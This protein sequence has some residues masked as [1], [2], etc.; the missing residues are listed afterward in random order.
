MR[1]NMRS[2]VR[3]SQKAERGEEGMLVISASTSA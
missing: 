3:E 2:G 1:A